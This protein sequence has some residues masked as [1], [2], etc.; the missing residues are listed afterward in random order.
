MEEQ[1]IIER[2]GVHKKPEW[3]HKAIDEALDIIRNNPETLEIFNGNLRR[4]DED[5]HRLL[6]VIVTTSQEDGFV[7]A[8]KQYMVLGYLVGKGLDEN[9]KE[10]ENLL[11]DV[12]DEDKWRL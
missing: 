3:V 12:G 5:I 1:G 9:A 7:K 2:L 4:N 8:A 6:S 10:L 11:K